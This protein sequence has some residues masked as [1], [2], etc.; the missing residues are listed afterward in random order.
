[1]KI[2]T[3]IIFFLTAVAADGKVISYKLSTNNGLP[4]NNIRSIAQDHT[5]NIYLRSALKSYVYNG[6]SFREVA[7]STFDTY[8]RKSQKQHSADVTY[9]NLGNRID[10][11]P[12]GDIV[13]HGDNDKENIRLHI[14]DPFMRTLTS[15]LKVTVST[16]ASGHIWITTNGNG[17]FLYDK[18]KKTF[19]HFTKDDG[20]G[21]IDSNFITDHFLDLDGHLWIALEHYGIA[22]LRITADVK[23]K[24]LAPNDKTERCN[25]IRMMKQTDDH[26]ILIANNDGDLYRADNTL[27]D[28]TPVTRKGAN[29]LTCA[30]DSRNRLWLGTRTKGIIVDGEQK[31]AGRIDCIIRDSK[32]RMWACGL[33]NSL[34][35]FTQDMRQHTLTLH[36]PENDDKPHVRSNNKAIN[37]RFLLQDNEGDIWLASD[38]GTFTFNPEELL[39][40]PRKLRRISTLPS[41]NI[42]EDRNR[43]IYIGTIGKGLIIL[44]PEDGRHTVQTLTTSDGLPSDMIQSITEDKNGQL[45]IGTDNGCAWYDTVTKQFTHFSLPDAPIQNFCNENSFARLADGTMVYGSLDGIVYAVRPGTV[46]SPIDRGNNRAAVTN[47]LVNGSPVDGWQ[48]GGVNLSH[49]QNS[50]TL[51]FSTFS[52]GSTSDIYYS[53]RLDNYDTEW[54]KPATPNFATYRNLPAGTYT[55]RLRYRIDNGKWQTSAQSIVITINPPL[56]LTWWAWLIYM[57]TT[58]IAAIVIYRH[59]KR[60]GRLRQA[61]AVEKQLTEYKLRFFTNISHEFRAPLTLISVAMQK[62][63]RIANIPS[64]LRQPL[65]SMEQSTER[66]TRLV[67]QL[68]EFRRMQNGKLTLTLQHTDIVTYLYNI[69]MNFHNLAESRNMNYLFQTQTRTVNGYIDRAHIDKIVYNLLSNAFK[70]TPDG[71]DIILK[72]TIP[73]EGIVSIS[74]SDTG[75]GIPKEQQ[76]KLFERFATGKT[77]TDSIGIGLNLTYELIRVHHGTITY[78]ENTGGGSVFTVTIPIGKDEYES[79]D[80]MTSPQNLQAPDDASTR[81]GF[82]KTIYEMMP[83]PLNDKRILIA[84]DNPDLQEMMKRELGMYFNITTANDGSDA[85]K[86]LKDNPAD[87]VISDI[88]MPHTNGYQLL[89]AIRSSKTLQHIPVI[90]LTALTTDEHHEKGLRAGA[91]AYLPKPFSLRVLIAWCVRL[92]QT[93]RKQAEVEG[94]TIGNTPD[95]TEPVVSSYTEKNSNPII[96]EA[97]DK[98]FI[99]QLDT[100]I[101]NHIADTNLSVDTLAKMFGIGRTTFYQKVNTLTGKTPNAYINEKRMYKAADILRTEDITIAEVAYKVGISY[102][103]YFATSFKKMFGISPKEYQ[104]KS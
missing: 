78:D 36:I 87:L 30:T 64:D 99:S 40:N 71:G 22:M 16:T 49:N 96:T 12:D 56:W 65:A 93:P 63:K 42:Y 2:L 53:Y 3:L 14:L 7:D 83:H 81:K 73:Q 26:T 90:L 97:K 67:N 82:S 70:Y 59:L 58:A 80:F 28:I 84:E 18:R 8:N 45:F 21:I 39:R 104:K 60:L 88:M 69:Y 103:Q 76:A 75:I 72:L 38:M 19:Q 35:M 15:N 102:P 79:S 17:I 5:G 92:M 41:K 43:N 29:I 55:F 34:Y 50:V 48:H 20:T 74:L 4:D 33:N 95:G 54:S 31:A 47:M 11:L 94:N 6:Y 23:V 25:N 51:E 61:V 27:T 98:K 91:D 89:K 77:H 85:L 66:M 1:M 13:Y 68:M 100:I 9:D 52:Y 44:T 62:T 24:R 86:K 32:N 46:T 57:T 101:D 10:I 37:P